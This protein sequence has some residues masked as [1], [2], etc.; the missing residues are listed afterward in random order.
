[1]NVLRTNVRLDISVTTKMKKGFYLYIITCVRHESTKLI[2]MFLLSV[3]AAGQS[4][5]RMSRIA[6]QDYEPRA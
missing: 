6:A 5:R 4:P 1:M 2:I 3:A